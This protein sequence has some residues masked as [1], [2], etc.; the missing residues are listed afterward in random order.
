M[1]VFFFNVLFV[2]LQTLL[3]KAMLVPTTVGMLQA[4]GGG[5]PSSGDEPNLSDSLACV[6][7]LRAI[8]ALAFAEALDDTMRLDMYRT[9]VSSVSDARHRVALEAMQCLLNHPRCVWRIC[10][11]VDLRLVG[12]CLGR[13]LRLPCREE[14]LPG[15][16]GFFTKGCIMPVYIIPASDR[17][18]K[19]HVVF[20]IFLHLRGVVLRAPGEKRLHLYWKPLR[21]WT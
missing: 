4:P 17:F 18:K 14:L 15:Q 13:F 7:Y 3:S 10:R 16:E 19:N 5:L 6:Y 1:C 12:I 21:F 9:M 20:A 8:K 2:L 11:I